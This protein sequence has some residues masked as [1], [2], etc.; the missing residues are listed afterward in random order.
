MFPVL[1]SNRF[2]MR[3]VSFFLIFTFVLLFQT[4]MTVMFVCSISK[5]SYASVDICFDETL[6]LDVHLHLINVRNNAHSA[7]VKM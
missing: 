5:M 1:Y 7:R 6:R 4:L 3:I 2:V